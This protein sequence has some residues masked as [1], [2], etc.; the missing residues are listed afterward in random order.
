MLRYSPTFKYKDFE[1][2]IGGKIMVLLVLLRY[3][4]SVYPF[5]IFKLLL[6]DHRYYIKFYWIT[7]E[8]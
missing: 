2:Y 6:T 5:G 1:D 4:D 3:T 7:F 8:L